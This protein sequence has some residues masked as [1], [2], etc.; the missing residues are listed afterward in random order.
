M[1]IDNRK[2]TSRDKFTYVHRNARP[3]NISGDSV[4]AEAAAEVSSEVIKFQRGKCDREQRLE[5]RLAHRL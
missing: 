3:D 5:G 4:N 1:V 2:C